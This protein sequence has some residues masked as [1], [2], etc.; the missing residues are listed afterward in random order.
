MKKKSIK[1]TNN[2]NS[3]F[4]KLVN[5]FNG[6][7]FIATAMEWIPSQAWTASLEIDNKF[8]LRHSWRCSLWLRACRRPLAL[9]KFILPFV[10]FFFFRSSFASAKT[11]VLTHVENLP[12]LYWVSFYI[13]C[14]Y[15]S[16]HSELSRRK[17]VVAMN[18]W[19][20]M[21]DDEVN[22]I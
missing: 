15:P 3:P 21:G 6:M 13:F 16:A 11:R 9:F 19:L 22:Y 4:T 12:S 10:V 5:N 7:F 18:I 17:Q 1:S 8:Y 14:H 2:V 20:T